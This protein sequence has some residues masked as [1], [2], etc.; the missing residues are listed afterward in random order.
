MKI[1]EDSLSPKCPDIVAVWNTYLKEHNLVEEAMEMCNETMINTIIVTY[2]IFQVLVGYQCYNARNFMKDMLL[3]E[4]N[5]K[6]NTALEEAQNKAKK[7]GDII[8][9]KDDLDR[10]MTKLMQK[11]IDKIGK[12]M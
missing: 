3:L 5:Q 12:N 1:Y 7:K 2:M 9:I 11:R 4:Q 10:L 6:N 8:Q